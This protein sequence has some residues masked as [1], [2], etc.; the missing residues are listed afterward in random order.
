MPVNFLIT[1][2]Q[3]ELRLVGHYVGF[4]VA[5]RLEKRFC[6]LIYPGF[7][8]FLFIFAFILFDGKILLWHG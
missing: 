2:K 7:R 6:Q 3:E 8:I 5:R 1:M 4:F